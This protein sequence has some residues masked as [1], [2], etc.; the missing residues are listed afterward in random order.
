MKNLKKNNNELIILG[1]YG[2]GMIAASIAKNYYNFKEIYFLNDEIL[3]N[4]GVYKK[5]KI[6]GKTTKLKFL[7][8]KRKYLFFNAIVDYKNLEKHENK[9]VIPSSK[10][11]TLIHPDVN[12]FKDT[13]KIAKNVLISSNVTMS[14]D[15]KI[16]SG[17][18]IMSNVFIGHNTIIKKNSFIA[19][20]A[21]IGGNVVLGKNSFIGLNSTVIENCKIGENSILGAGAVLTK[22]IKNKEVFFGNPAKKYK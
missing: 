10:K 21:T 12:Y 11:I 7:L 20:G 17:V 2:V 18:K 4:I 9:N 16:E 19:A 14:T 6:I 5:Y 22:N 13:V 15:V 3:T 8:K 1:G